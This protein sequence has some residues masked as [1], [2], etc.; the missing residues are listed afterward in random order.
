MRHVHLQI[1]RRGATLAAPASPLASRIEYSTLL[2]VGAKVIYFTNGQMPDVSACRP[3][4]CSGRLAANP[5]MDGA[6][7]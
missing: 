1:A 5:T 3:C 2:K 7:S 6:V 4:A